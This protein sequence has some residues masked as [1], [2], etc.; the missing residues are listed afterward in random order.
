MDYMYYM[1]LCAPWDW[2]IYLHLNLNSI[3]PNVGKYF[4][5]H[6]ASGSGKLNFP[7]TIWSLS[8]N[9]C[10]AKKKPTINEQEFRN[11]LKHWSVEKCLVSGNNITIFVD[12]RFGGFPSCRGITWQMKF[13]LPN[14]GIKKHKTV[15]WHEMTFRAS[16][17]WIWAFHWL[18]DWPWK[19]TRPKMCIPAFQKNEEVSD[20]FF[21]GF[22]VRGSQFQWSWVSGAQAT[23]STKGAGVVALAGVGASRNSQHI[24]QKVELVLLAQIHSNLTYWL[25]ISSKISR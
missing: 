19:P 13:Y 12:L 15:K 5:S 24:S 20:R 23:N 17:G 9:F 1:R 4:Q 25:P 18:H 3:K 6:G 21:I 22:R 8:S 14:E 2:N 7:R 11:H 16:S 10:S